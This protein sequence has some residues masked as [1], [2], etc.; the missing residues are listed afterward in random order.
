MSAKKALTNSDVFV[1]PDLPAADVSKKRALRDVMK[2]AYE[3][4]HHPVFRNGELFI[5]GKKYQAPS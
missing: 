5:Q 3:A 2:R 4:G 1:L